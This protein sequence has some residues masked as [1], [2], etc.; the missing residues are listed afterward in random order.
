M[1]GTRVCGWLMILT[2]VLFVLLAAGLVIWYYD[3]LQQVMAGPVTPKPAEVAVAL[4]AYI[5]SEYFA[6]PLLAAGI[7]LLLAGLWL[8]FRGPTPDR[9]QRP[10]N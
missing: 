1:S 6:I 9:E 2:A 7:V 4:N 5:S 8:A 10:S 3:N